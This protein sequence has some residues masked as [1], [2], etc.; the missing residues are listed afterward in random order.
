MMVRIPFQ[1]RFWQQ[2]IFS[3]N[4]FVVELLPDVLARKPK[5]TDG[6]ESVII[7]DGIPEVGTDRLEKLKGVIE[8]IF[9]KFGTIVS[10]YYPKNDQGVTK[11][12]VYLQII[13]LLFPDTWFN[14]FVLVIDMFLSNTTTPNQ[15]A[16]LW[17]S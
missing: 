12:Y 4:Y 13:P 6:F 15:L 10:D 17:L 8:K 1:R 7:V 14:V 11:G 16:M 9:S 3:N 2:D 5:E